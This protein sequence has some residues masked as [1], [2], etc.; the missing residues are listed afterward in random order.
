MSRF[1]TLLLRSK[2]ENVRADGVLEGAREQRRPNAQMRA[3]SSIDRAKAGTFGAR[4]GATRTREASR[5]QT[6]AGSALRKKEQERRRLELHRSKRMC[7]VTQRRRAIWQGREKR[8]LGVERCWKCGVT[9]RTGDSS[10]TD[11]GREPGK[12]GWGH[13]EI[14]RQRAGY[15]HRRRRQQDGWTARGDLQVVCSRMLKKT[16]PQAWAAE[17]KNDVG[18]VRKSMAGEKQQAKGAGKEAKGDPTSCEK[19]T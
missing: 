11:V 12:I 16:T 19:S 2:N 14:A 10:R 6:D 13:G 18:S 8:T 5:V 3:L 15:V 7:E 4:C 1:E 9:R 17:D